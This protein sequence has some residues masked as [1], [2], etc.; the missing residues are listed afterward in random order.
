MSLLTAPPFFD[1]GAIVRCRLP[2]REYDPGAPPMGT[3]FVQDSSAHAHLLKGC[4]DGGAM[5]WTAGGG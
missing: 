5:A 2:I 1:S 4:Y 3:V